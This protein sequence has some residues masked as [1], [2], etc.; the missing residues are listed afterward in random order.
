MEQL[1]TIDG[2]PVYVTSKFNTVRLNSDNDTYVI[3][4]NKVYQSGRQVGMYNKKDHSISWLMGDEE[5]LAAND[6]AT[7]GYDWNELIKPV[8][9][10]I[11]KMLGREL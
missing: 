8:D 2:I 4:N 6:D 1:G 5:T 10:M 9:D 7:S 3:F 11:A